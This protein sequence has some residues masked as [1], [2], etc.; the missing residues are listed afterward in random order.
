MHFLF[1]H[2]ALQL[3]RPELSSLPLLWS[4]LWLPPRLGL[5]LV[6]L[7][8]PRMIHHFVTIS[9]VIKHLFF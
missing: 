1:A 3:I 5:S 8:T 6:A 9:M 2:A 4:L 7:L